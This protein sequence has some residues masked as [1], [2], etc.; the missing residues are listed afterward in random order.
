MGPKTA[1]AP[2][3]LLLTVYLVFFSV[4]SGCGLRR[5]RP[6]SKAL[7][8]PITRAMLLLLFSIIQRIILMGQERALRMRWHSAPVQDCWMGYWTTRLELH[9]EL[10]AVQSWMASSTLRLPRASA[11]RLKLTF[12]IPEV[13]VCLALILDAL[14]YERPYWIP[15]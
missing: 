1:A 6:K 2:L 10:R 4:V 14:L 3:C 12:Q 9:Q 7:T 8:Q 5:P 11:L 15:V 13:P